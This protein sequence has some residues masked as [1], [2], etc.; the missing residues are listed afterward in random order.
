MMALNRTAS[1]LGSPVELMRSAR[2]IPVLTIHHEDQA[3]PLA[4]ALVAGGIWMLEVTLRT[5]AGAAAARAIRDQVPDAVVGLGTVLTVR[6][7]ELARELGLAFAFSPGVT[8]ELLDA[9]ADL[10]VPFVPGV[11]TASELMQALARGFTVV[12]FFPAG[13]AGG[14]PALKALAGPFPEACFCPTGGINEDAVAE[15]LALPNVVAVGGSWL[16]PAADLERSDWAAITGRAQRAMARL[17][18][19]K[20]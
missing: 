12:K 4:Q 1:R 11:Q 15:W 18:A 6:D 10:G 13:S 9:A 5:P 8:P 16:V 7:L 17:D 2:L 14:I 20:T 3:V 19:G